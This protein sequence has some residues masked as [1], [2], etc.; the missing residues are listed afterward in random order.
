MHADALLY[1]RI[2]AHVAGLIERGALRP[3]DRVPSVRRLSQQQGVSVA[4]VLLAYR[5]LEDGGLIEVRPQ[6]GHYVRRRG[7]ALPEPR[8][9]DDASAPSSTQ[10]Q[11]RAV[12]TGSARAHTST[13]AS[14]RTRA[15]FVVRLENCEGR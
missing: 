11:A 6:S 5:H 2:A 9:G 15:S 10:V 8:G 1:E 4:T 12:D 3:G 7:A 13:R 14:R